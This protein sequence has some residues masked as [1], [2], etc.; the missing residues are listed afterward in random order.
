[1]TFDRSYT[2]ILFSRHR[3]LLRHIR[4]IFVCLLLL[5]I[6]FSSAMNLFI[7]SKC[8]FETEGERLKLWLLSSYR[9]VSEIRKIW[10][11]SSL[12]SEYFNK[13]NHG[14]LM[15]KIWKY[16]IQ[17]VHQWWLIIGIEVYVIRK[18]GKIFPD[19]KV[20]QHFW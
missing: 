3:N 5:Q 4:S 1:M 17:T 8:Q 14:F 7:Y 20:H 18:N 6:K 12:F 15:S 9:Y 19:K 10:K 2:W 11:L 13:G 16:S